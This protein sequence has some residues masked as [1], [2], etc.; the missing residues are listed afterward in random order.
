VN[1]LPPSFLLGIHPPNL[2]RHNAQLSMNPSPNPEDLVEQVAAA[3][4]ALSWMSETDAPFE[5][6]HWTGTTP[7]NLPPEQVC[8][9]ANLPLETPLE[10][11]ALEEFLAPATQAQPWHTVEEASMTSQFQALQDLLEQHLTQIQVYRLGTTELEIYIVGQIQG[12]D[13]LVLHTTAVE[14]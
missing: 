6:L 7:D 9:Q 2:Q 3:V 5:V 1:L 14:T 4:A 10:T 12:S 8:A 13:W 11:L